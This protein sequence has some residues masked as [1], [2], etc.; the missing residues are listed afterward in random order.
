MKY[1]FNQEKNARLKKIMV[2]ERNFKLLNKNFKKLFFPTLMASIAGN[3]AIIVDAFFISLFMGPIYLSV[4]QSMQPLLSF[5]NVIYWMMGIGGSIL[6]TGAKT[7]FD[8]DKANAIF[9]ISIVTTLIAILCL[10]LFCYVFPDF[11]I[12]SLSGSNLLKPLISQYY[13]MVIPGFLFMSYMACLSYFV[14]TDGFIKLQFNAFLICNLLNMI[15][16]VVF[17]KFLNLGISGAGLA[18]TLGSVASAIYIPIYFFNP[19]RSLKFIKVKFSQLTGY[20]AGICKAGFSISSIPLYI[21]LKF[22]FLNALISIYLAELGLSALNMCQNTLFLVE[23]FI[24]GTSQALLPIVTVY[25]NEEDY[26][27][28]KYVVGKSLKIVL[29]FG[30]FFTLLFLIFPQTVLFIFNVTNPNYIPTVLNVI[31]IFSLSILG[32]S[33]NYMYLFY[34]QSVEFNK[35]ANLIILLEGFILPVILAYVLSGLFGVNGFWI[36]FAAA[37]ILTLLFIF[38][39]SKY[40]ARKTEGEYSGF[41]LNRRYDDNERRFEFTIEGSKEDAINLSGEVKKF[42]SDSRFAYNVSSAIEDIVFY[43]IDANEK[44]DFIDIIIREKDDSIRISIKNSG[45]SYNPKENI[46]LDSGYISKL[47]EIADDIEFSQILGL[48]NTVITIKN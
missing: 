32:F 26:N 20:L 48:N 30:I 33:I 12:G 10:T 31:R 21:A 27:G 35:L 43:I 45:I 8:D 39:Y 11:I 13:Y 16:D 19:Q 6:C 37:E 5:E 47:N 36:S 3:F 2:Y 29:A 18:L 38:I 42:L 17:M 14:K 41:F 25:Y 1:V 9:T 46:D 4:V 40:V 15:L 24:L 44:V 23:I 7:D 22:L 34:A 28:V